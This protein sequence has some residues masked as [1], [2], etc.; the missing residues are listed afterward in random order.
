MIYYIKSTKRKKLNNFSSA[1]TLIELLVVIIIIGIIVSTISFNFAPD[2]LRLATDQIIK[3]IRFTQ[4][5]ALK[6]DKYQPFPAYNGTDPSLKAMEYNRSKYWFKQ[7]WQ[8]KFG[9]DGD[10]VIYMVFSDQPAG[11]DTNNFDEKIIQSS[12]TYELAKDY[13]GKY[14]YGGDTYLSSSEK[15]NED[16]NL[17]RSGIKEVRLIS[18]YGIDY[19]GSIHILFDNEGNVFLNEG[20][21]GDLGD[22]N[23]LQAE[24]KI[25][26]KPAY[27]RLCQDV[28]C[29]KYCEIKMFASGYAIM[30]LCR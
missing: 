26:T 23:P 2:K 12:H 6:D 13:N 28:E 30:N 8:I 21:K 11:G 4:S 29:T 5:L 17:S 25:L 9:T 3:D 14:M 27:L 22:I 18:Q 19:N 15:P 24:R 1:F 16:Y 7:W 10:D 20:K